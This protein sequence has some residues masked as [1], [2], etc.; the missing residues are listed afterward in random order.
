MLSD[1]KSSNQD[2]LASEL[3]VLSS[4]EAELSREPTPASRES[5]VVN[6]MTLPKYENLAIEFLRKDKD[7][8]FI[9][10]RI[11]EEWSMR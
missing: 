2:Q 10:R 11:K 3:S 9:Q 1:N 4:L 5:S 8:T 6:G 7:N